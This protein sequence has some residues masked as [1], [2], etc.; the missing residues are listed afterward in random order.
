M[1]IAILASEIDGLAW[2]G[3]SD[4]HI[5]PNMTCLAQT[6]HFS[7]AIELRTMTSI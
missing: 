7:M 6:G 5:V 1:L 2:F 4:A 3:E